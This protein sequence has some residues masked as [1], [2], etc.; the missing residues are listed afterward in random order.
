MSI[1]VYED[2][3]FQ[4]DVKIRIRLISWK[5]SAIFTCGSAWT[6]NRVIQTRCAWT[7]RCTRHRCIRVWCWNSNARNN[8]NFFCRFNKSYWFH[9]K[10]NAIFT[11]GSAWTDSRVIQTG[12]AWTRRCTRDRCRRGRCWWGG[13]CGT[14][15]SSISVRRFLF[16]GIS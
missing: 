3:R 11:S 15:N 16:W 14:W 13:G 2:V 4:N 8:N 12:C 10:I 9:E 6:G 7:I 1:N 5:I